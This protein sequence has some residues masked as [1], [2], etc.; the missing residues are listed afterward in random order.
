MK[1]IPSCEKTKYEHEFGL[2]MLSPCEPIL[3]RGG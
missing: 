3:I 2:D 1:I